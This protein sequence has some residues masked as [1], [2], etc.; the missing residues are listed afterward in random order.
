MPAVGPGQDPSGPESDSPVRGSGPAPARPSRRWAV[1]VAAC[2][3]VV[4]ILAAGFVLVPS[5]SPSTSNPSVDFGAARNS[6]NAALT[7]YAGGPWTL[8]RVSGI[9]P[10]ISTVIPNSL[11]TVG[12][13]SF[14]PCPETVVTFGANVTVPSYSGPIEAG[15][16]SFWQLTYRNATEGAVVDVVDGASSIALTLTGSQCAAAL[17]AMP[18]IP[19]AAVSS[20]AAS[21]AL[22][23]YDGAFLAQFPDAGGSFGL[24]PLPQVGFP[25]PVWDFV[26][27]ACPADHASFGGTVNVSTAYVLV[28]QTAVGACGAPALSMGEIDLATS[29]TLTFP[30]LVANGSSGAVY[31]STILTSSNNVTW[32]NLLP[33]LS[34]PII[35]VDA[36]HPVNVTTGGVPVT[37]G[38]SLTAL[39]PSNVSI[40]TFDP[41][42]WAWSGD[43][44]AMIQANE[45]FQIELTGGLVDNPWLLFSVGGQGAFYGQAPV[46]VSL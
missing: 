20:E 4:V 35:P 12:S 3:A 26:Y 38:W 30:G 45:T 23:P 27:E 2:M 1:I 41:S 43:S 16:S 10:R 13:I 31:E 19:L 40:A 25:Y 9:D 15:D 6:A 42:T 28:A 22:G 44:G 34:D 46:S 37:S 7:G 29:L 39:D 21:A 17:A 33:L 8:V 14:L 18:A 5:S 24:A 11:F 36:P 32:A